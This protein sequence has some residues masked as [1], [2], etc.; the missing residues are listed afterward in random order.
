MPLF[1]FPVLAIN[2]YNDGSQV[3]PG[4][5]AIPFVFIVDGNGKMSSIRGD[6]I[7]I[8]PPPAPLIS[9]EYSVSQSVGIYEFKPSLGKISRD[10]SGLL[11]VYLVLTS[12]NTTANALGDVIESAANGYAGTDVRRPAALHGRDAA[13]G[14]HSLPRRAA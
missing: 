14:R 8:Q 9:A 13:E 11:K 4:D 10:K 5:V 1:P 6:P 12:Q 2:A 3:R 7:T